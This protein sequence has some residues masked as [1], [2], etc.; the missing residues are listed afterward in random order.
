MHDHQVFVP[1]D[2]RRFI[3]H[4]RTGFALVLVSGL[5]VLDS[6]DARLYLLGFAAESEHEGHEIALSDR[7]SH[8]ILDEIPG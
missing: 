1:A 8:R 7:R 4:L 2:P 5:L 3:A 6:W